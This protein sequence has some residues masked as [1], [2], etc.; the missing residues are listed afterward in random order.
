[1]INLIKKFL[2]TA[3]YISEIDRFIDAF[4][5]R[6]PQ[7]SDSQQ[8]EMAQ[9]SQIFYLRD[10]VVETTAKNNTWHNF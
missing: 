2:G 10:N 7:K 4:D 8:K 6:H 1:M 3:T 9:Y 5:K